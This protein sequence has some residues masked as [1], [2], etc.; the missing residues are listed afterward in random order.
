MG[1]NPLAHSPINVLRRTYQSYHSLHDRDL[2]I[3][4]GQRDQPKGRKTQEQGPFKFSNVLREKRFRCQTP[5]PTA[6]APAGCST[7]HVYS[8]ANAHDCEGNVEERTRGPNKQRPNRPKRGRNAKFKPG[9]NTLYQWSRAGSTVRP[10][11]SCTNH[12]LM[13]QPTWN[14]RAQPTWHMMNG[15]HRGPSK[16]ALAGLIRFN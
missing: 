1:D 10:L 5:E 14:P 11:P 8:P 7:S 6:T 3:S 4:A 13:V 9:A 12:D 2:Q 16:Q 15:G